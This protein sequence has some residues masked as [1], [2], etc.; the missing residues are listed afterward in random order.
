MS[1]PE[2]SATFFR[3][4]QNMTGKKNLRRNPSSIAKNEANISRPPP[5]ASVM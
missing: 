3:V 2:R 4:Q 1:V 5:M